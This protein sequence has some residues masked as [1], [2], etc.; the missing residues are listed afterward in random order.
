MVAAKDC[1]ALRTSSGEGG[2]IGERRAG[3]GDERDEE[4]SVKS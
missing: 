4:K 1:S 2:G 3:E